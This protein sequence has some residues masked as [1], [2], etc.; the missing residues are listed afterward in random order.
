MTVIWLY[1]I[2]E[3]GTAIY[4]ERKQVISVRA[5]VY[6]NYHDRD[7]KK[8]YTFYIPITGKCP[9]YVRHERKQNGN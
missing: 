3:G 1:L 6:Q 4:N 8:R 9:P 2:L 5:C 7:D